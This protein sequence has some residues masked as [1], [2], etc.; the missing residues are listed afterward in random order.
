MRELVGE[1]PLRESFWAQLVQALHQAG[2][3]QEAFAAYEQ[4]CDDLADELGV[5]PGQRCASC[6]GACSTRHRAPT[7]RAS[8]PRAV[9]DRRADGL[10]ERLEALR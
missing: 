4:I 8:C 3:S 6:T 2:R 1:H 7:C 5:E 9:K 10:A